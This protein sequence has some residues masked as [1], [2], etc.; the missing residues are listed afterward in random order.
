MCSVSFSGYGRESSAMAQQDRRVLDFPADGELVCGSQSRELLPKRYAACMTASDKSSVHSPY[1]RRAS[2]CALEVCVD[3]SQ[4]GSSEH[5]LVVHKPITLDIH[6]KRPEFSITLSARFSSQT[7]SIPQLT[8]CCTS[9]C[10]SS[11]SG[12]RQGRDIAC[13]CIYHDS[14]AL[15]ASSC[16][17][18]YARPFT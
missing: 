2:N 15:S 13:K 17:I 4:T 16:A 6:P 1:T 8:Y 3:C 10:T 7:C 5:V 14:S 9:Y 11:I 12:G 18:A